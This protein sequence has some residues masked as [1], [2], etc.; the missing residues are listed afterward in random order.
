[1]NT[2]VDSLNK[3]EKIYPIFGKLDLFITVNYLPSSL[4]NGFDK[5]RVS[6]NEVL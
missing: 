5:K 1:V 3:L 6:K 4:K 2:G